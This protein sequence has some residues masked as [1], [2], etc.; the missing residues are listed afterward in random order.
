MTNYYNGFRRI[1]IVLWVITSIAVWVAACLLLWPQWVFPAKIVHPQGISAPVVNE[2]D[3]S[4]K[5]SETSGK[6]SRFKY[7]Y[8]KEIHQQQVRAY[9]QWESELV[10]A[11]RSKAYWK[12]VGITFLAWS[13]WSTLF[14][15]LWAV[16]VWVV[17][18]F[19]SE[20]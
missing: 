17:R 15:C 12:N 18:G 8:E 9:D 19:T 16:G 13:A 20:V 14:W 6:G 7:K 1:W 3:E 5:P 11:F 10:P 2:F 4:K